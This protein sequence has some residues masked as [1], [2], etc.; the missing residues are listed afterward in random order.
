M[1]GLPRPFSYIVT[2][3]AL[4]LAAGLTA[5]GGGAANTSNTSTTTG[6]GGGSNPVVGPA[7]ATYVLSW[8]PVADSRVTGYHIYYA[9][10]PL[11]TASS[12]QS[13]TVGAD[14]NYTFSPGPAGITIGTTVYLAVSAIGAGT[15]SPLSDEISVTV[16]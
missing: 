14:S 8:E 9:N 13:V 4:L 5:C 3:L 16:E 15:E 6:A 2:I 12:A 10:A 11:K 1:N 7:T